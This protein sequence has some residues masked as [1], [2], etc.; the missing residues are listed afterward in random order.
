MLQTL[1]ILQIQKT[2]LWVNSGD[3]GFLM[4]KFNEKIL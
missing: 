2:I 1:K 4:N 3:Y